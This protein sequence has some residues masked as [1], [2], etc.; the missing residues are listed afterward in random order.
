[1]GFIYSPT[2]TFTRGAWIWNCVEDSVIEK[3]GPTIMKPGREDESVNGQ[4]H[5]FSLV[6]GPTPMP[7]PA[8]RF[9]SRY[10]SEI[11]LMT[12]VNKT[13]LQIW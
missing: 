12:M 7:L 2:R 10:I 9:I 11:F 6:Y 5:M 3:M 8:S 4:H 13:M 1:M